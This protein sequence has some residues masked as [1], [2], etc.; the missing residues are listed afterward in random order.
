MESV[1]HFFILFMTGL[2]AGTIDAIA[3]GGGLISIPVLLGMGVAPPIALGTNK[4]QA[5][6]GMIVASHRYYQNQK[7]WFPPS[8]V[9][10][11]GFAGAT[12][13]AISSQMIKAHILNKIIIV[14]MSLILVYTIFSPKLG[15]EDRRPK[16]NESGFFIIFGLV[17]GFYDGFLGPGAGSLWV[18]ALTFFLGFNFIKANAYSKISNL[19]SSIVAAICFMIGKNIDYHIAFCMAGGQLIGNRFGA[20]LA[21]KNGPNLVRIIFILVVSMTTLVL[22][23][24]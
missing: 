17:L 5:T 16:L 21:I 18:F 11:S 14:L 2:T 10:L 13:G 4:L 12:L 20:Y 6:I 8:E 9:L 19:N 1:N 15:I 7:S 22:I 3:G 23:C 24:R